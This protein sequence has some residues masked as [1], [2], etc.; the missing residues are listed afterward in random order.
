MTKP[1]SKSPA[2]ASAKRPAARPAA[3]KGRPARPATPAEPQ[4]AAAVPTTTTIRLRPEVRRGL[5][6]LHG[7]VGG[8]MNKLVNDGLAVYVQMRTA[9][10]DEELRSALDEIRKLRQSDP[11]FTQDF[12]EVARAEAAYAAEDPAQGVAVRRSR[13]P[14][15]G[16]AVSMVRTLIGSA[17]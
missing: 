14:K 12:A 17:R 8:T 9:A 7:K 15:A 2:A 11:M 3:A 5:E 4:Q 16:S 6:F 1:S 13:R 10:L